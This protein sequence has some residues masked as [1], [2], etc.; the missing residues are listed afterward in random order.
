MGPT[1]S[2]RCCCTFPTWKTAARRCSREHPDRNR[3]CKAMLWTST[4]RA[5][6]LQPLKWVLLAVEV[7]R[8]CVVIV[9][10]HWITLMS[11]LHFIV[12]PFGYDVVEYW[13]R[14]WCSRFLVLNTI[15]RVLSFLYVY[16]ILYAIA[17][18]FFYQSPLYFSCDVVWFL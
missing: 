2:R 3:G 4:R 8:T 12:V 17:A 15:S 16:L 9:V 13:V 11:S 18:V 6:R 7:Y 5:K 14:K 10:V 1:V